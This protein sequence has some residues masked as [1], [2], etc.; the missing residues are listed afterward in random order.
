MSGRLR[1]VFSIFTGLILIF[2]FWVVSVSAQSAYNVT[3]ASPDTSRF[4]QLTA[5]LDVHDPAGGFVHGLTAQDV[6]LQENGIQVP[7]KNL[8]E[9]KPGVQFV[10]AITPGATFAIR[11]ATGVSRYDYLREGLLAGS[12][13][14]QPSGGDDF[15]LATPGGVLLAHSSDPASLSSALASFL[16]PDP[17]ATPNLE[18]LASALQLASDPTPRPGMERAILFITPPQPA[19]ISLG[20]QSI[21]ASANQQNIRIFVWLVASKEAFSAPEIDLLRNLAGQTHAAFFEFSHDET[22]PD[23]ESMLEP[24]RYIYQVSYD[25]Q[26]AKAGE[27]QL[28]AQVS[29]DNETVSSQPQAFELNL[30]SPLVVIVNPP[31][32]IERN[33]SD[34][35][36]AAAAQALTA[37]QPAEQLLDLQ[38]SFPDGHVRPLAS[39]RLF[40]DGVMVSEVTSPPF[41]HLV[42]DLRPYTQ[43]GTHLLKAEATDNL[44]WVGQSSEI[45]VVV[46][47]PSTTQEVATVVSHNRLLVIGLTVFTSATILVLVLIV[48]G[49]IRPRP[50]PGQEKPG[51]TAL[52]NTRPVGYWQ[53]L[54]QLK[55]PVTQPIKL[56]PV[57]PAKPKSG[58]LGW[59]DLLPWRRVKEPELI[60]KAYLVPL[61]GTDEPTIPASL[62]I[63]T[64]AMTLG[65]DP[66]KASLVI[67]HPSIEGVHARINIEDKL[68]LI[69]DAGTVAGTWVNYEQVAP[70]GAHLK[71]ADIIHL[72]RVGFRFTLPDPGP[73]PKVMVTPLEPDA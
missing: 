64:D 70:N 40:V 60:A 12:W 4:P 10:L 48:G 23:L 17:N 30:L 57:L 36:T 42:W 27:Q 63:I 53:R 33:F 55:D 19:E 18:V 3:L 65:S 6:S 66:Q 7:V 49:R 28:V 71:H 47:V 5:Y 37:L 50:Y 67:S 8:Q 51:S 44:G 34:L 9:N 24:L 52:G 43:A 1:R 26:A 59:I 58:R 16:P 20:L 69:T 15:S 68:F 46:T 35:P 2:L 62:Q 25:S 39:T 22:I 32:E 14:A 31:L 41:E 29:L 38:V 21:L 61:L 13:A 72:G 73:A 54:R 11:D 56:G 45:S